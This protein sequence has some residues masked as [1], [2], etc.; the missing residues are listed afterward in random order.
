[1]LGARRSMMARTM[2]TTCRLERTR[3]EYLIASSRIT[4]RGLAEDAYADANTAARLA[5][6]AISAVG[7]SDNIY[8]RI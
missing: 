4:Q 8:S 2:S 3:S 7:V 6:E 1:M 5:D